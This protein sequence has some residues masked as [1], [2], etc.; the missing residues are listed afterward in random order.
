MCLVR[1]VSSHEYKIIKVNH[2]PT[3]LIK[4][5]KHVNRNSLILCWARVEL[6]KKLI[7]LIKKYTKEYDLHPCA[8][9]T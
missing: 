3:D 4:M 7:A 5:I 8:H 2:N 6:Y 9:K 1:I